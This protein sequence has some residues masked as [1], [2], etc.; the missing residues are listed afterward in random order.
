MQGHLRDFDRMVQIFEE[1]RG[2]GEAYLLFTGDLVHGPRLRRE[3]WPDFLGDFY[4]D[5]SPALIERF[6]EVAKRHPGRIFSLLGNHEHAHIGGPHTAKFHLDEVL[7]LE[8]ELGVE[9]ALR[10]RDLFRTFPLVA[11]APCGVVFTHGAPAAR[12]SEP[13]E[14]EAVRYDGFEMSETVD[15]IGVPV[16]G[17]ILW[18]RS[19]TAEAAKRFVRALGSSVSV[20]GHDV[21]RSGYEKIGDEQIIVSTSFGLYDRD[22]IYL[23]LDLGARYRSVHDLRE[24]QQIVKLYPA[25]AQAPA[26]AS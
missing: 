4:R 19:A 7:L 10:T 26:V 9:R 15:M 3:E 2:Q 6:Q 13:A 24:G 8:L 21:I 14:V 12:I 5:E 11:I 1:A 18:A 25:A 17:P 23:D 22:K 20:F 16:L